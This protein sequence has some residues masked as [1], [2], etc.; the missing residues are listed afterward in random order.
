[1]RRVVVL[2][3]GRAAPSR[4]ARVE[5]FVLVRAARARRLAKLEDR[6]GSGAAAVDRGS[7]GIDPAGRDEGLAVNRSYPHLFEEM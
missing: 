4:A 1:M 5:S 2:A 7:G 3:G 6:P